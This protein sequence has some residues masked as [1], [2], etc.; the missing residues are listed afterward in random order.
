M[1]TVLGVEFETAVMR[2]DFEGIKAVKQSAEKWRKISLES[3][4]YG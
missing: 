2:V 1:I 3:Q 4:A